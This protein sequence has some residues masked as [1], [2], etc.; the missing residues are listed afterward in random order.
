MGPPGKENLNGTATETQRHF[1]HLQT[2]VYKSP[3]TF[4]RGSLDE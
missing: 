4:Q 1:Y 2:V 3:A